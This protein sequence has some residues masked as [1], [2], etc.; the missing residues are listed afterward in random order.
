[1]SGRAVNKASVIVKDVSKTDWAFSRM[2]K[3]GKC[4]MLWI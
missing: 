2:H 3:G 4:G 1:M